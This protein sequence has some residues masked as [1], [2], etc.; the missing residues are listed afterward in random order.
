MHPQYILRTP[1]IGGDA[2]DIER[3]GVGCEDRTRLGGSIQHL[4]YRLLDRVVLEHR[5]DH[6]I[7]M[8]DVVV[9]KSWP[10]KTHARFDLFRWQLAPLRAVFVILANRRYTSIERIRLR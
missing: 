6:Q 1:C 3:R 5:L 10:Q 2:V 4:E 8:T 7:R 9:G